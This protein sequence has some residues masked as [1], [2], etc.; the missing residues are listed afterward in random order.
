LRS[1][2]ALGHRPAT[3]AEPATVAF[4]DLMKDAR[5]SGRYEEMLAVLVVAEW[6]Y[7]EWAT[8][9]A[10][11]AAGLPF[12]LGEWITLHSGEGFEA[13]VAYLRGQL[14]ALWPRLDD[15]QRARVE[16]LFST[17]VRLERAFFDA[18]WAGFPVAT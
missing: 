4:Q 8:P 16:A 14:D 13:V 15:A 17:A 1:L 6:V 7:L 12:W 18:A 2:K 10:H 5:Q 9:M 11:R 3:R